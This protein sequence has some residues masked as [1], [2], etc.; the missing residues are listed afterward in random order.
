MLVKDGRKANT[1]DLLKDG[2]RRASVGSAYKDG[3]LDILCACPGYFWLRV[4]RGE[5]G[6]AIAQEIT[7][8]EPTHGVRNDVE[9]DVGIV[10]AMALLDFLSD[11]L[12]LLDDEVVKAPG[13]FDV[14]TSPVIAKLETGKVLI[15]VVNDLHA[16]KLIAIAASAKRTENVN[17]SLELERQAEK[18]DLHRIKDAIGNDVI[19]QIFEW[20]SLL[21]GQGC[22]ARAL[23]TM[24]VDSPG[25]QRLPI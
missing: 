9:L 23:W 3:A 11:V 21:H 19:R 4:T 24:G 10:N 18:T 17:V 2:M 14:V 1:L 25:H 20:N 15:P 6:V 5:I 16:E 12:A 22:Q 7:G 13:V 8:D